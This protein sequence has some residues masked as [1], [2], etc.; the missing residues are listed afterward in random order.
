[1]GVGVG[2]GGLGFGVGVGVGEGV[3]VGVGEGVAV[4]VGPSVGVGLACV[5]A[6]DP[7]GLVG[8]AVGRPAFWAIWPEV[9]VGVPRP[10]PLAAAPIELMSKQLMI[11]TPLA[12]PIIVRTF[13]CRTGGMPGTGAGEPGAV[14]RRSTS[15]RTK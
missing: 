3:A 7:D 6:V 4:T 8:V 14:R 10:P 15:A 11:R 2:V 9:G 13:D 5:V 12:I 1:M